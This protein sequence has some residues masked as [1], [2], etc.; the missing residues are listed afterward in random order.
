[1]PQ[2]KLAAF[3]RKCRSEM[4]ERGIEQVGGGD[5]KR[6]A[7][8]VFECKQCGRLTAQEI[9]EIVDSAA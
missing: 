8:M 9:C 4:K 2:E 3:C 7:V 1:M 6:H 5:K